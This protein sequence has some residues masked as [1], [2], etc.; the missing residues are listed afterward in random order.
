MR[1]LRRKYGAR[2]RG[3]ELNAYRQHVFWVSRQRGFISFFFN[4]EHLRRWTP[5]GS[6][7]VSRRKPIKIFKGE[8]P[9]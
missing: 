2:L 7:I 6:M 9:C 8:G 4:G 1:G 5:L 3:P